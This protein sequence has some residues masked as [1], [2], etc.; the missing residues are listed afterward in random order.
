[1]NRAGALLVAA[2]LGLGGLTACSAEPGTDAP[3]PS[4][5]VS[6]RQGPQVVESPGEAN[7]TSPGEAGTSSPGEA[8]TPGPGETPSPEGEPNTGIARFGQTV[9][10]ENGLRASIGAPQSFEPGPASTG[11]GDY[12]DRIV[13]EVRL[14][15]TADRA[16]ATDRL[17]ISAQSGAGTGEPI[18]DPDQ[19]VA[20]ITGEIPAGQDRTYRIAFGVE[21]RADLLVVVDP[22][23][24]LPPAAFTG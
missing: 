20:P 18:T 2:I 11:G 5:S 22:G 17:G 21:D 7:S 14:E 16:Y 13:L 4:A 23:D 12:T 10:W 8:G 1:M 19:G 24:G 3:A 6:P 9:S 15:N